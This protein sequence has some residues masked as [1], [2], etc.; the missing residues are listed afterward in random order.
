MLFGL[1]FILILD[2]IITVIKIVTRN[3]EQLPK[4]PLE[5]L[6]VGGLREAKSSDVAEVGDELF[7]NALAERLERHGGLDLFNH[8]IFFIFWDRFVFIVLF[9]LQSLPRK[10]GLEVVNQ[11]VADGLQVVS[12]GLLDP[13]VGVD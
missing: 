1:L 5:V 3:N 6:V 8:V 9:R 12:S 2:P 4:Q 7:G 11:R 13:L 10:L